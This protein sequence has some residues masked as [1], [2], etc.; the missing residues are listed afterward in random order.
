MKSQ[1]ARGC[2]VAGFQSTYKE[3]NP[4]PHWLLVHEA[5]ERGRTEILEDLL[6]R[7]EEMGIDGKEEPCWI[8][9][10]YKTVPKEGL[11]YAFVSIMPQDATLDRAV[12]NDYQISNQY[13]GFGVFMGPLELLVS[14]LEEWEKP[15]SNGAPLD[16]EAMYRKACRPR[17]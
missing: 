6:R 13:N 4:T 1:A 16:V 5:R 15:D 12:Q 14:V 3:I 2:I 9:K 11:N 10:D 7:V 17:K 8:A